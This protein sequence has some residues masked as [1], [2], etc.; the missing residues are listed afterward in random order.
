MNYMRVIKRCLFLIGLAFLLNGVALF[1]VSAFNLG[2]LLTVILGV[3][4]AA[5]GIYFDA[6]PK[7]IKL[8]IA[9]PL[10][11]V[12]AL[13]SFLLVYGISDNVT[14]KEDAVIVLGA[15]VNG[16]RVS[17][18]LADRLDSAV[19]YH[20]ENPQALIVVSGGQGP[21]EDISEA[22]AMEQYLVARGVPDDLII[23]EDQ[24]TSTHENF[25]FSKKILEEKLGD[26][27]TVAYITNDYHIYRA[28]GIARNTGI[29]S[30]THIHS[31]TRWHTIIPGV[32]RECLAVAK[33][34]V[35]GN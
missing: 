19:D 21:G 35:F 4:L 30:L 32:L 31:S 23:K 10:L 6:I 13:S 2:N 22:E 8:A 17:L 24:S 16:S 7:Y 28:G 20:K 26:A 5:G 9:I 14:Y 33:F 15:G 11:L 27:Y 25:L 12:V 3:I 29:K 18:S 34:R 1:M